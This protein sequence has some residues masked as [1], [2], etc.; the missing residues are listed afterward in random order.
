MR[1]QEYIRQF[2]KEIWQWYALHKRRL[3]WRDLWDLDAGQ[4]AYRV[5]VSEIMLQQT[6]VARVILVFER[7]LQ[8]FPSIQDLARATNREVLVAW[9]G[10]GYNRR[11]L[12][13]RDAA[14]YVLA[15]EK[16]SNDQFPISKKCS[17]TNVQAPK[18]YV[19]FPTTMEEL[20]K[21]PGV[22][23]YTAAA[24]CNFAFNIPTPCLD[25]NIRRVLHL[26][27]IGP[28]KPDGTWRKDDQ[29]L[30]KLAEEVLEAALGYG[31]PGAPTKW[32]DVPLTPAEW[33]SALMDYGALVLRGRSGRSKRTREPGRTMGTRFV[34]NRI[35]RGKIVEALRDT[36]CGYP[37]E[38]LG[39]YICIDWSSHLHRPW[40]RQILQKLKEDHLVSQRG[41][42]YILA[43]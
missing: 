20:Q 24:I 22:G 35:F 36:S 43:E 10:M 33:H 14:R 21:I 18:R 30:L 17:S 41:R 12:M 11:A 40:L 5:L 38:A 19:K 9:K 31:K 2:T 34:P 13:L 29:Y 37:L 1:R 28:P 25:T 39:K 8:Q 15:R 42:M 23:P 3:P 16:I 27:F 4:R 7:F 6:Q 26:I 32:V